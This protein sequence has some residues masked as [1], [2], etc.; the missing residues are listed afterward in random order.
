MYAAKMLSEDGRVARVL[1]NYEPRPQQIAMAEAVTDAFTKGHHLLVEAGTGVG[2]SFAYLIPAIEHVLTAGGCIVVSTHTIALQ[3][4]LIHKDIP[5]LQKV[6]RKPFKAELVKGR[7]NYLG[8][9]RLERASQRQETLFDTGE[10]K[11]LW[12]IEQWAYETKDGSLSDMPKQPSPAIWDQVN[13]DR[14][15]CMGRRCPHFDRCFFYRARRRAADAQILVVNHALLFSHLAVEQAGAAILPEF[16]YVVLDEAHTAEA[17]AGDHFGASV[18]DAQARFLFNGLYNERTGRGLLVKGPGEEALPVLREARSLAEAYFHSLIDWAGGRAGWNGRLSEPPPVEER[19][20]TALNALTDALKA[21]HDEF[22]NE[23]ARSEIAGRMSRCGELAVAVD[24][25]HHQKCEGFVYWLELSPSRRRAVTLNGRPLDVGPLLK[26]SLF[27]PKKSVI[28]TSATLATGT[29]PPFAYMQGR[30]GLEQVRSELFGSP[31]DFKEQVT[32]YIEPQM[33]DPSDSAAFTF[34]AAERMKAYLL[35]SQGRAFVLFT[36]YSMMTECEKLLADFFVTH[37]MTV[38]VQGA[39]LPRSLML[40][41]FRE[42]PRAVLFG[43]DT[44]WAGVDVPGEALSNVIITRLPFAPPTH[45]VTEARI[46]KI[47][48][49]GGN[50]FLDFQVPEA[51][52]KFKQGFGRLIRSKTDRGM[53]VI[54]DPRVQTKPYGRR[55]LKALPECRMVVARKAN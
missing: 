13:S 23:Q 32:I 5:L 54:L 18:T 44:F 24:M 19:M 33:P 22:N 6:F 9:R 52:L 41:K 46:E 17:V 27:D 50:P 7:S 4:Q 8:L 2:K 51:V 31:F 42:T 45:P 12:D 1:P 55:F 29:D 35:E 3:E 25:L 53:V 30:L 38:F 39:G 34:A 26:A 14:H 11:A 47:R 36:S 49:N 43:T 16:D 48:E 28:M 10:R 40:E 21:V 20:S 15:D 37:G